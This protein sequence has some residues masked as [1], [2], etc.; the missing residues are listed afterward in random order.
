[1]ELDLAKQN[2]T[3]QKETENEFF[4]ISEKN[5]PKRWV[6]PSGKE[7]L[8]ESFAQVKGDKYFNDWK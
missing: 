3:F 1:M 2:K 4:F 5:Q 7:E 8:N 6:H